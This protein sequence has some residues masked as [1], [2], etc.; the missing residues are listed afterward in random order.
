MYLHDSICGFAS[1]QI[2]CHI[3]LKCSPIVFYL[4]LSCYTVSYPCCP[5]LSLLPPPRSVLWSSAWTRRLQ[6]PWPSDPSETAAPVQNP[7]KSG[8]WMR[9]REFKSGPG[10]SSRDFFRR[11]ASYFSPNTQ[12]Q[13][14]PDLVVFKGRTRIVQSSKEQKVKKINWWNRYQYKSHYSSLFSSS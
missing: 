4:V 10:G 5:Y 9:I 8:L 13:N 12:T 11:V 3:F 1:A 14:G 7:G 2:W 6:R